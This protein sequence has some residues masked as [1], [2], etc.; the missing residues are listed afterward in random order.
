MSFRLCRVLKTPPGLSDLGILG[1]ASDLVMLHSNL[2][3]PQYA[4]YPRHGISAPHCAMGVDD[5][6]QM[7]HFHTDAH[8]DSSCYTL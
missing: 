2:Q 7:F 3:G 6:R 8:F 4:L 1:G 5:Q